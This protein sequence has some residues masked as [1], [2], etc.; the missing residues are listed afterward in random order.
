MIPDA[1]EMIIRMAMDPEEFFELGGVAY[2][3][4][5]MARRLGVPVT[6]LRVVDIM[7]GSTIVDYFGITSGLITDSVADLEAM[8][9]TFTDEFGTLRADGAV[10]P[11]PSFGTSR[12]LGALYEGSTIFGSV[13]A[14]NWRESIYIRNRV[15]AETAFQTTPG[16]EALVLGVAPMD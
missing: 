14:S 6:G 9:V 11:V 5:E 7:K 12:L 1:R 3:S 10:A 8:G 16:L 4:A 15:E 13:T 2:F